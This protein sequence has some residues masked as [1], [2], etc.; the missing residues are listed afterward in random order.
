MAKRV[1]EIFGEVLDEA[2]VEKLFLVSSGKDNPACMADGN[3]SCYWD[4]GST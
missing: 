4:T 3:N 1:F 2:P